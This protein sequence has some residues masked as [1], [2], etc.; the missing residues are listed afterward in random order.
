MLERNFMRVQR[1]QHFSQNI[2]LKIQARFMDKNKLDFDL[3][4]NSYGS[5]L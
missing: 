2:L 4:G 1:F 3:K 5:E